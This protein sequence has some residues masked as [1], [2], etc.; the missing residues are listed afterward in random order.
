[1]FKL[2]YNVNHCSL[3]TI[4][5]EYPKLNIYTYITYVFQIYIYI[6]NI[7][8]YT[9]TIQ[10]HDLIWHCSTTRKTTTKHYY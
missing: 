1:M 7:Y 8:I 10:L 4:L 3:L 9:Y 2:L 5:R 6:Y